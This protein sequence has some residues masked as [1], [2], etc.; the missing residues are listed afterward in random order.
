MTGIPA[1]TFWL[2]HFLFDLFLYGIYTISVLAIY[3]VWDRVMNDRRIYFANFE[4][5]G[6]IETPFF[7]CN[8]ISCVNGDG[9]GDGNNDQPN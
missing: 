8:P 3:F 5:S 9:N 1:R 7:H 2:S 6:K 4:H